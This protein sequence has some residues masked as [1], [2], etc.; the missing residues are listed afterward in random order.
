[1]TVVRHKIQVQHGKLLIS[2]HVHR[3]CAIYVI[4]NNILYLNFTICRAQ[5]N[6]GVEVLHILLWLNHII[7]MGS[8]NYVDYLRILYQWL[9]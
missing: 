2:L 5:N 4:C 6:P 3:S 9:R 1:L 7:L 8:E